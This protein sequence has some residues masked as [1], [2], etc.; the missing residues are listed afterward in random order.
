MLSIVV[1]CWLFWQP[2]KQEEIVAYSEHVVS[3]TFTNLYQPYYQYDWWS[4]PIEDKVPQ[5]NNANS[6]LMTNVKT[7]FITVDIAHNWTYV[8]IHITRPS[9]SKRY[10]WRYKISLNAWY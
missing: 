4:L 2:I 1:H 9:D 6:K 10:L 3:S 5:V 7:I 8:A